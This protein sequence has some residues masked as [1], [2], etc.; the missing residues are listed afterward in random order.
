[1]DGV[2][3]AEKLWD[4]ANLIT[5]FAA[6]QTLATT[7]AVAK[8]DLKVLRGTL[9]HGIAFSGTFIF[10][11]FYVVAIMWC[12]SEGSSLSHDEQRAVWCHATEGRLLAV[13]LFALVLIL[14]LCGHWRDEMRAANPARKHEM[15]AARL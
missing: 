9:G 15:R 1:M 3:L 11:A 14:A 13:V 5:G 8:G 12:G 4:M 2:N 10:T 6:A 7:F